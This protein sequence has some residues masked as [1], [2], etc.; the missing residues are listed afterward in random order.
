MVFLGD[1]ERIVELR[2]V[3]AILAKI[4]GNCRELLILCDYG[5]K[6]REIADSLNIPLGSACRQMMECRQKLYDRINF[7]TQVN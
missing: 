3:L 7:P 6:T 1:A 4:G 5:Y 2:Q